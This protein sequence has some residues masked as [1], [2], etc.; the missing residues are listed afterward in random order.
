MQNPFTNTAFSMTALTNAMNILPINYGRVE[1]L[2]LFPI[3]YTILD[4]AA[5]GPSL[6]LMLIV[7]IP[8]LPIILTYTG[9]CY[10]VFRGKS[11]YEHTY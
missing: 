2:N 5:S 9:Y 8:L 6:S 11:N 1:N 4:A 10:Y 7:I 3:Q